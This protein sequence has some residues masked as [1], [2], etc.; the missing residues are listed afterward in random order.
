MIQQVTAMVLAI[1]SEKNPG[2]ALQQ[3]LWVLFLAKSENS[4]SGSGVAG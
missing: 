2:I 1:A 4:Q 3:C